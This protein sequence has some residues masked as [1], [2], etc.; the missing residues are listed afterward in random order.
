MSS[1]SKPVGP[2][3]GRTPRMHKIRRSSGARA[4]SFALG[5]VPIAVLAIGA[6]SGP[7]A[8]IV[9]PKFAPEVTI[10]LP[11]PQ[12]APLLPAPEGEPQDVPGIDVSDLKA[13]ERKAWWR[14]MSQLY[15]P[16][17]DVAVSVAQCLSESRA[18]HACS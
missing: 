9:E 14:W 10:A 13:R 17:D 16:C 18:C 1:R 5:S 11:G 7:P 12:G 8:P 4:K 3:G 15:A 2:R 6:C